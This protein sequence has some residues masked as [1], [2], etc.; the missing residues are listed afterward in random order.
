MWKLSFELVKKNYPNTNICLITDTKSVPLFK[1]FDFS[2]VSTKL[3]GIPDFQKV[4]ALGK[5]YAYREAAKKGPFLHVDADVFLW[6]PLPQ[7]LL[8]SPVFAQSPD[9][10]VWDEPGYIS[11]E[12]I[13]EKFGSL[14]KEWEKILKTKD[15]FQTV[16]MGIF[17]GTDV[18]FIS[19][20]CDFVLSMVEDPKFRDLWAGKGRAKTVRTCLPCMLE[21][22]NVSYFAK[23][24]GVK[25]SCL[26]SDFHDSNRDSYLKYTH[27]M[28][29]KENPVVM[30]SIS[31]RVR[32][33]PYNLLPKFVGPFG[34]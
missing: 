1:D 8:N 3:D 22:M 16:N 27:L 9:H 5:I 31:D 34:W 20:Y 6:A 7:N 2:S 15:N 12:E 28:D 23:E 24:R 21:Q 17:G 29:A 26:L 11:L 4:W 18:K 10:H 14:P 33:K 32:T 30:Q 19:Q 25:I 13:F